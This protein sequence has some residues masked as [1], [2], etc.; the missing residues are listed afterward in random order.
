MLNR[1]DGA[2]M[3]RWLSQDEISSVHECLT[4]GRQPGNNAVLEFYGTTFE[5]YAQATDTHSWAD[6]AAYYQKGQL[7]VASELLLARHESQSNPHSWTVWA[8]KPLEWWS[9]IRRALRP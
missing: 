6:F 9:W 1:N 8:T 4:W 7:A 2:F 5:T 3:K